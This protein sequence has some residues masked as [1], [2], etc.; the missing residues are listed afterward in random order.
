[1]GVVSFEFGLGDLL[2]SPCSRPLVYKPKHLNFKGFG[3]VGMVHV[4]V[5]DKDVRIQL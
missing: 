4:T 5:I 3:T 2:S 1:M